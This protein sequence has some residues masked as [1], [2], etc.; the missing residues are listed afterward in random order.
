[1]SQEFCLQTDTSAQVIGV[2]LLN[3]NPEG[4]E[5]IVQ[6]GSR[7][8]TEAKRK[9]STVERECLAVEVFTEYFHQFLLEKKFTLQVDQKSLIL[10][11]TMEKLQRGLQDGYYV[12]KRI[13]I[14]R[15]I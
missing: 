15:Y 12:F 2:F 14:T 9:Y 3:I 7:F 13:H 1:M 11:H 5:A 6:Y 4:E 10:L 8:L